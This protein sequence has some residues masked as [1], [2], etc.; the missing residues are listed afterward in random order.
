VLGPNTSLTCD[1]VRLINTAPS[2]AIELLESLSAKG[3][4][5]RPSSFNIMMAELAEMNKWREVIKIMALMKVSRPTIHL[6]GLFD[7]EE[8]H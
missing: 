2:Q 6:E 3:V 7:C 5:L 4:Q 1:T 8:S